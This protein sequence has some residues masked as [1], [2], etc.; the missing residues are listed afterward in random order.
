ML[1]RLNL[2]NFQKIFFMSAILLAPKLAV[3]TLTI[4]SYSSVHN[5]YSTTSSSVTTIYAGMTAKSGSC[6]ASPCNSCDD[7]TSAVTATTACNVNEI[8]PLTD[9][10]SFTVKTDSTSIPANETLH[11]KTSATGSA[12]MTLVNP[13]TLVS[14]TSTTYSVLWS[15]LCNKATSTSTNCAKSFSTTLTLYWNGP[16]GIQQEVA[17]FNIKFRYVAGSPSYATNCRGG[18]GGAYEGICYF[19]AFPGDSKAYIFASAYNQNSYSV[20]DLS[21]SVSGLFQVL[22]RVE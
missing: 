14:N 10:I 6:T 16:T 17:T 2:K 21:G 4:Q 1:Q 22:T 19:T 9:T 13:P 15:E 11:I 20:G 5:F 8:R 12:D 3:A 7:I 18:T